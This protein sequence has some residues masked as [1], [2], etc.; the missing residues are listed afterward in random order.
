MARADMFLAEVSEQNPNVMFE[1][2]AVLHARSDKPVALLC[3]QPEGDIKPLLPADL[4]AFLYLNYQNDATPEALAALLAVELKK[5]AKLAALLAGEREHFLSARGMMEIIK[6]LG[7]SVGEKQAQA[8]SASFP[9]LQCW[10]TATTDAV[11]RA[12]G[13]RI[14]S[15]SDLIAEVCAKLGQG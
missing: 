6:G 14:G 2:G 3:R 11:A 7:F 4:R 8:L 5:N 15:A 1:L 12:S 10:H 13:L 9:T